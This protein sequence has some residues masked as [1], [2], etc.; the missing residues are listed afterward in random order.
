MKIDMSYDLAGRYKK[1]VRELKKTKEGREILRS[2]SNLCDS[3]VSP[4]SP[5]SLREVPDE[6]INSMIEEDERYIVE[7]KRVFGD[8]SF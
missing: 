3:S 4:L 7:W 2:I 8:K 1:T 6:T 5:S